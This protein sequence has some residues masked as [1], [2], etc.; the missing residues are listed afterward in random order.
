MSLHQQ[1]ELTSALPPSVQTLFIDDPKLY[2]LLTENI[3][4]NNLPRVATYYP[5]IC[6]MV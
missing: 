2:R 6:Y 3:C 4:V 1:F 5:Y